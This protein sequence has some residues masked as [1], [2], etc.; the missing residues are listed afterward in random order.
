MIDSHNLIKNPDLNRILEVDRKV[1]EET[2]EM[3]EQQK[4]M[5]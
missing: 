5:Q 4:I 1:K 3:I 2:I